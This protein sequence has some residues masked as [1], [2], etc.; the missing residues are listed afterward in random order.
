[1][2][3]GKKSKCKEPEAKSCHVFYVEVV[4]CD[5]CKRLEK[6]KV[7]DGARGPRGCQGEPGPT[8]PTGPQGFQGFQGTAGTTGPAGGPQGPQGFQGFQGPTGP[9]GPQGDTGVQGATG[10]SA[11][12]PPGLLVALGATATYGATVS[13]FFDVVPPG[14][15]ASNADFGVTG[16][17]YTPGSAITITTSGVYLASMAVTLAFGSVGV[18]TTLYI[19][20]SRGANEYLA[21]EAYFNG[22]SSLGFR[23]FCAPLGLLAGDLVRFLLEPGLPSVTV[24]GNAAP[25]YQTFAFVQR[26]GDL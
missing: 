5:G 1:M 11:A 12:N 6:V 2:S 20:I 4:D 9:T 26:I 21:Y 13:N 17:T 18:D 8:G 19:R 10:D 3:C 23:S 7:S 15:T 24:V 25:P 16:L 14:P 22:S